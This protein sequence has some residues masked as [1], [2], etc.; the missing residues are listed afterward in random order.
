MV[1]RSAPH[2][3]YNR[4][5]KWLRLRPEERLKKLAKRGDLD[6]IKRV[7]PAADTDFYG[8]YDAFSQFSAVIFVSVLYKKKS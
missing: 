3:F 5:R 7:R 6:G 2:S 8:H 4:R 1:P